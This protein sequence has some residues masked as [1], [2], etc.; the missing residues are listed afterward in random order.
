MDNG[1]VEK[2]NSFYSM[3]SIPRPKLEA[4]CTA[5]G[6]SVEQELLGKTVG[7]GLGISTSRKGSVSGTKKR[8]VSNKKV[9]KRPRTGGK[10]K[11]VTPDKP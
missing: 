1:L 6:I 8:K 4:C 9:A 10:K 2:G 3:V 11:G 7:S 5:L